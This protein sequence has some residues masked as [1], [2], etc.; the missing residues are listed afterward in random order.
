MKLCKESHVYRQINILLDAITY[1]CLRYL[2]QAP[3]SSYQGLYVHNVLVLFIIVAPTLYAGCELGLQSIDG[4]SGRVDFRV[5]SISL[6]M[7]K[8]SFGVSILA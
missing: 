8:R 1:P 2:L 5:V 3:K 7:T 6:N 4:L